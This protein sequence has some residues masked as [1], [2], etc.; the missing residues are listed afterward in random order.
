MT[1]EELGSRIYELTEVYDKLVCIIENCEYKETAYIIR[2][3]MNN[4]YIELEKYKGVLKH[5]VENSYDVAKEVAEKKAINKEE[6]GWNGRI[7]EAA[8]HE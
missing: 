7:Y 8:L 1:L 6:F 2:K 5:L 3:T 4:M